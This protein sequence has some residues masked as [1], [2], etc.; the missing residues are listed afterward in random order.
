MQA[1]PAWQAARAL[2]KTHKEERK[3]A[4]VVLRTRYGFSEYALHEYAKTARVRWLADHLEA[5]LAQTLATRA[6][7]AL[8]RV[9]VGKAKRVRFK[10]RG[11]GLD[12]IEN[13]RND[14]GLHF[15][16]HKPEDG[17]Q[18]FL[19]W[20]ND[21]LPALID[22]N[23]PVVKHGLDQRKMDRRRRAANPDN[24]DAQGRPKKR[25][26]HG[27]RWRSSRGYEATRKRKT[28]NE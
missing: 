20:K 10:S 9:C 3:A 15:E 4:V 26:K 18:G 24:Y 8:N 13:K 7:Q 22:W 21:S 5:V 2:P 11:R 19:V 12:S 28:A 25:G 6:Y 16:L 14:T 17:H 1:D 23:D 27:L